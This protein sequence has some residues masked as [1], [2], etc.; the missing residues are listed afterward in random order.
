M[1]KTIKEFISLCPNGKSHT[2]I[3]TL[4]RDSYY[5]RSYRNKLLVDSLSWDVTS[6]NLKLI[7]NA[8]EEIE[9][10]QYN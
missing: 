2:F 1:T 10:R 7:M 6:N 5:L 4:E 8:C 3:I 9:L